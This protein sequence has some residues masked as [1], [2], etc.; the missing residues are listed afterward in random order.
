MDITKKLS[1]EL[2]KDL[3]GDLVGVISYGEKSN[4]VSSLLLVLKV[5]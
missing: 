4:K 1:D 2:S 3:K 5:V